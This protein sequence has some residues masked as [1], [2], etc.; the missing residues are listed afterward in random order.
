[1]V[2]ASSLLLLP[3]PLSVDEVCSLASLLKLLKFKLIVMR[4]F[5]S[6]GASI[7]CIARHAD[8]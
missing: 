6:G 8:L 5:C 2:S 1:M 7:A 4:L 3:S